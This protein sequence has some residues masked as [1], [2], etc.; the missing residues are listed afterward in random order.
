M[1]GG[2]AVHFSKIRLLNASSTCVHEHDNLQANCVCNF[3]L[4]A[5][6]SFLGVASAPTVIA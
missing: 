3:W 5:C 2:R 6:A 1:T 4:A